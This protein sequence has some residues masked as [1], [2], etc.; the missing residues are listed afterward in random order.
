MTWS[1]VFFSFIVSSYRD[2][3]QMGKVEIN[4]FGEEKWR[5]FDFMLSCLFFLLMKED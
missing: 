4:D 2:D 3:E 5:R 1:C